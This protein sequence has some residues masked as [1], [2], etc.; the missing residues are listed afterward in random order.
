[1]LPRGVMSTEEVP[2]IETEQPEPQ[3]QTEEPG[4][5]ETDKE[6]SEAPKEPD[7]GLPKGVKRK[8]ARQGAEVRALRAE[9]AEVKA[10]AAPAPVAD[11]QPP[12]LEQHDFDVAK[13]E[14]ALAKWAARQEIK[15][16]KAEAE[17]A[18]VKQTI[19]AKQQ[20]AASIIEDIRDAV[21]DWDDLIAENAAMGSP[22]FAHAIDA[23]LDAEPETA[24]LVLEHLL[25]NPLKVQ[26]ISAMTPARQAAEI[27]K[28][29][30]QLTAKPEPKTT[31]APEPVKPVSGKSPAAKTL[32]DDMPIS[33]WMAKRNKELYSR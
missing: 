27:G 7:D 28:I 17:Q 29:E 12:T 22:Q 11:E 30:M 21:D 2:V 5:L 9:L 32:A 16:E 25:R 20:K 8:L 10:K 23:A 24:K 26:Q 19:E 4:T 15:A 18:K 33:E 13:H 31:K 6:E 3:E 1:M 14:I